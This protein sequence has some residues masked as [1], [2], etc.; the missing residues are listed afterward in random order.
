MSLLGGS[1]GALLLDPGAL[2]A[3]ASGAV[4]GL[5]G[6]IAVAERTSRVNRGNSGVLAF[7]AINI[8]ISL[9]IPGISLGGH[10]GGLV[11]GALAAGVLW[12]SRNWATYVRLAAEAAPV[13]L[14]P[15]LTVVALG[16]ATVWLTLSV[17][18]PRWSEPLF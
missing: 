5:C 6:A 1:L 15:E 12:G 3:G 13:R 11:L 14:L 18:A 16:A 10:I 4:F 9:S 2:T 17:V 7:L 8:V